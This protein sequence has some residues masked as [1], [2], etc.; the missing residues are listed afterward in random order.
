LANKN[1]IGLTI[2]SQSGGTWPDAEFNVHQKVR[3]V[4]QKAL[5][6]F[7]LD[8]R[9]TYEVLLVRGSE[10]RSLPLDESLQNVG[11]RDGDLLLIRT[12]GRTVDG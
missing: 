12:V 11:L 1:E 8:T 10:Q 7:H 5:D 9:L 4:L 2:K 6:T 3:H